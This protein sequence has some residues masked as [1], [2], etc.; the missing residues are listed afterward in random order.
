M[1]LCAYRSRPI[2]D[3]ATD[4]SQCLPSRWPTPWL[5]TMSPDPAR[6][7]RILLN[8]A[9]S[10]SYWRRQILPPDPA[11]RRSQ[12]VLPLHR[13][14]CP[15]R[16]PSTS[17]PSVHAINVVAASPLKHGCREE[18]ESVNECQS[19]LSETPFLIGFDLLIQSRFGSKLIGVGSTEPGP[20]SWLLLT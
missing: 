18:G 12:H 7:C 19:G 5:W 15:W 13:R 4:A 1:T 20:A 8:N 17:L 16:P 10:S 3:V 14:L 6:R 9:G 2:R 11:R